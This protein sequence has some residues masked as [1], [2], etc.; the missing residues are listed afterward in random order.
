MIVRSQRAENIKHEFDIV[1]TSSPLIS[2]LFRLIRT[3]E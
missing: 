2:I 3:Y 1:M